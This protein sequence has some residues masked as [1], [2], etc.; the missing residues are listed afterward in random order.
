M[1]SVLLY[2]WL[3]KSDCFS[4]ES[5][6]HPGAQKHFLDKTSCALCSDAKPI[7]LLGH[8]RYFPVSLKKKQELKKGP[9]LYIST[10]QHVYENYFNC[11]WSQ[12][13]SLERE[14]EPKARLPLKPMKHIVQLHLRNTSLMFVFLQLKYQSLF[15][16]YNSLLFLDMKQYTKQFHRNITFLCVCL[17][18]KNIQIKILLRI[19][20]ARKSV[21]SKF[22]SKT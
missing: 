17:Q 8:L 7:V 21:H 2:L 12:E 19:T 18:L 11:N 5:P 3:M 4:Q 22:T 20:T 10:C 9:Y 13:I 16:R 15:L 6:N 14:P 1:Y